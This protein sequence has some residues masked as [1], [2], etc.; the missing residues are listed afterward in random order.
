M[1]KKIIFLLKVDL[2]CK[3]AILTFDDEHSEQISVNAESELLQEA[4]RLVGIDEY[5]MQTELEIEKHH[6]TKNAESI[7]KILRQERCASVDINSSQQ[8]NELIYE[9]FF[10]EK[11]LGGYSLTMDL[12]DVHHIEHLCGVFKCLG[13]ETDL[14]IENG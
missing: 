8:G 10:A 7:L 3:D 14:T 6:P 12:T 13:Y 11:V 9:V 2:S 1:S 5:W 4:L